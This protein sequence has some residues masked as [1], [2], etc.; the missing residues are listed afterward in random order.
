LS[1]HVQAAGSSTGD[2]LLRAAFDATADGILI[3]GHGGSVL[4]ANRRF[5]ELWRVPD[6]L[7][8]SGDDK[9]LLAFA[10]DQLVDG[11]G[12]VLEVERLYATDTEQT[13]TIRFRDGRIFERFTRSVRRTGE[14]ARLWSFRDVTT[15]HGTAAQLRRERAHF[16]ALIRSSPDMVWLKDPD[17]VYLACNPVFERL[18]A[19]PEEKIVGR[20][21]LDFVSPGLAAFFRE[22]DLEAMK[23]GGPRVNEEWLTNAADGRRWLAETIKTPVFDEGGQL[24][25]VLGVARDITTR[26]ATEE[27]LRS[28]LAE[29]DALLREIHHRVK[30]NLSVIISLIG[31]QADDVQD[32]ATLRKLEDLQH[33]A[34]A[35]ALVHE[36][37]Y[38]S[39]S[40]AEVDFGS[41]LRTLAA[42]V[43]T[44][45]CTDATVGVEVEATDVRLHIEQA[46]PCGLM[47]SEL[48][49]NAFKYAFP[50][51]ASVGQATPRQVRVEM[52]AERGVFTLT[53]ADNGVGLPPGL[54][55]Q[56]TRSLGLQVVRVLGTQIGARVE[57]LEGPGTRCR[58]TFVEKK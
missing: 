46:I 17:G 9:R 44:A 19:A 53:V 5:F 33:R 58:V 28:A 16:A 54:D 40:L 50:G 56:H 55:W 35:M 26:Q 51:P 6:E 7:V 57:M 37:L 1:N 49:T 10:V 15:Q 21:D 48:L 24:L 41:Y 52:T 4:D 47:V 42:Q 29:K 30:N 2:D 3:V 25:G 23:A 11:P 20:N 39:T 22:N 38:R 8:L 18:Y 43:S 32:H 45:V 31:L 36:S 34:R 12:F 13:D 14:R 27:K